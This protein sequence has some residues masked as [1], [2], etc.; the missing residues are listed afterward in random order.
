MGSGS[1]VNYFEVPPSLG[2]SFGSIALA[3]MTSTALIFFA[4]YGFENIANLSEETR[5]PTR[6]IPKGLLV[7]ILLTSIIYLL[8]ASLEHLTNWMERIIFIRSTS[9]GGG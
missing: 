9:R 4:Y 1:D 3:I 2:T 5:D 8:V 6:V 7:S